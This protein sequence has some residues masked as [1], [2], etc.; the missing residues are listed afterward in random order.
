MASTACDKS[1]KANQLAK[2]ANKQGKHTKGVSAREKYRFGLNV[3]DFIML[4]H[5]RHTSKQDSCISKRVKMRRKRTG[6]ANK[7]GKYIITRSGKGR[8]MHEAT[9]ITKMPPK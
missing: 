6:G 8:V 5:G 9:S 2:R 7:H 1:K 3:H 4:K